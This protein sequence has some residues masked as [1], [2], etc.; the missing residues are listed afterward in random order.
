MKGGARCAAVSDK[1]QGCVHAHLQ[2]AFQL[3]E[4]ARVGHLH[5]IGVLARWAQ[6]GEV[7]GGGGGGGAHG[8]MPNGVSNTVRA[9]WGSIAACR[10]LSAGSTR[11]PQHT[12]V[13]RYPPP[14]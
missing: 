14:L 1:G 4:A 10:S 13:C 2:V 9:T 3:E 12:L 7:A 11:Q 5:H 6:E 8:L